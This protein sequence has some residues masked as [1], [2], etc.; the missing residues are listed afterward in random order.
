[1]AETTAKKISMVR[2]STYCQSDGTSVS[3][4]EDISRKNVFPR[5]EY[6]MFYVLYPIV[7]RLL[8]LPLIFIYI[9]F[10]LESK[11]LSCL[12]SLTLHV[13]T[14]HGHYYVHVYLAKMVPLCV[15]ITC[16]T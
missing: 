7:T 3:M 13:S 8:T 14:V 6:N 2:V 4:L 5:F 15:K 11:L 12:T 9:N 16:R 1:V 10:C